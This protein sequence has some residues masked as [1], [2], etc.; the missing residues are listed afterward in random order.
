MTG[1]HRITR[2][3]KKAVEKNKKK[4]IQFLKLSKFK[5]YETKKNMVKFRR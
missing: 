4:A 5:D 1:I 3:S 2:E